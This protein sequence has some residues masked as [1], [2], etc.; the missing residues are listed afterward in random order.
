MSE[1][2]S[3]KNLH[4]FEIQPSRQKTKDKIKQ[5]G[6]AAATYFIIL[7]ALCIFG[8]I[9]WNGVPVLMNKGVSFIFE[10]PETLSVLEIEKGENI[11]APL[12]NYKNMLRSNPDGLPIENV[13]DIQI[14]QHNVTFDLQP[15]S[16]IAKGYLL[17]IEAENPDFF[18]DYSERKTAS[19]LGFQLKSA[20]EFTLKEEE[21]AKIQS[22][23]PEI[24]VGEVKDKELF[25]TQKVVTVAKGEYELKKVGNDALERT[26]FIFKIKESFPDDEPNKKILCVVP[27]TQ[28]ITV[29]S[30]IFYAAFDE[31]ETGTLPTEKVESKTTKQA[32]KIFTLAA[33]DYKVQ[34]QVLAILAKQGLPTLHDPGQG[35]I[36]INE[37]KPIT[38]TLEESA[39]NRIQANNPAMKVANVKKET[40]Q[41]PYKSFSLT[42]DCELQLN[43]SDYNAFQQANSKDKTLKVNSEYTHSYSGGGIWGPIVGT[44][45]LVII[46]M[47]IALFCGIAA[48]TYLN[49][50]ANKGGFTKLVRLAMLNLAGVPSIVFGLFGLG[51]F[52]ML[53]PVITSTP[54]KAAKI[55]IPLTIPFT[56]LELGS[57]P[58]LREVEEGKIAMI[59]TDKDFSI[60]ESQNFASAQ[61]MV[62]FYDGHRYL[63]F[64]GWGTCMLAGGFTL[65][66]MVLP[67]IITASEESL[68]SVPMGFR[69]ASLALGATKWQSIRT[70][71]LP[72]A[73]PGIL[74]ASVLGITRVAGETAPI[75]FTA[76]AAEKSS[77][78]WAG[79]NSIG[80]DAFID[81]LQ[82]SVQALP[83]HI[84]TVAARIPQSEYT[85]PMQ[86]GAVLVF[87]IIVLLLSLL[88][89]FMRNHVRKKYK[90]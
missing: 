85:Q 28:T 3:T 63:A 6:F 81:F 13:K 53:A 78:P 65:A 14:P 33:G 44:A 20:K 57:E 21:F 58:T 71:V 84:F 64:E 61:N 76:A 11:I 49:E 51:L 35:S 1:K 68:K 72:Y 38:L 30:S 9:L 10:K 5:G 48:A 87:M 42:K 8:T 36:V 59:P 32:A 27:E 45:L 22:L 88:S 73:M 41:L 54:N 18:V 46:C 66:I 24:I 56:G 60:E 77:M 16:E 12:E 40:I 89:M 25:I 86:Y 4:P 79:I 74:T 17:D 43:I 31:E 29:P 75:M 34:P 19:V 70:A 50:Y 39:F 83:Y 47:V 37:K 55:T 62:K 7:C 15:K 52:V 26:N 69:E 82:Q 23:N 90:W 80:F 67:V 2:K